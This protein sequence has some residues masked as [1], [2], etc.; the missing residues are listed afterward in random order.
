VAEWWKRLKDGTDQIRERVTSQQ[1]AIR[2]SAEKW[3]ALF[4]QARRQA[5]A[6]ASIIDPLGT[7]LES[8][9][10]QL[11]RRAKAVCIGLVR[12][13]GVGRSNVDGSRITYV[14]PEGPARGQIRFGDIYGHTTSLAAGVAASGFAACLYGDRIALMEALRWKGGDAGLLVASVGLFRADFDPPRPASDS[15]SGWSFGIELGVGVGVPLISD[16]GAFDLRERVV[17]S[18]MVASES[19][20]LEAILD[21]APDRRLLRAASQRLIRSKRMQPE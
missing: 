20:S 14:R 2:A 21:K 1:A 15:S 16:I 10:G 13:S 17:G 6:P 7:V 11:D 3:V 12:Q 19:K 8:M 18:A 4:E 5:D 9:H